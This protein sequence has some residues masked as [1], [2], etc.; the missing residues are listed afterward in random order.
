MDT[1][2]ADTQALFDLNVLSLISLV[3]VAV[4]NM[5]ERN[6]GQVYYLI[7]IK[8]TNESMI[9]PRDVKT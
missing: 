9:Y 1:S 4:P 7:I 6:Q 3:K 5:I 8:H 2:L